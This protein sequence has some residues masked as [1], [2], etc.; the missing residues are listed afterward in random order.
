MSEVNDGMNRRHFLRNSVIGIGA[1]GTGLLTPMAN[2]AEKQGETLKIKEYRTL[3]RTGFKVSDISTGFVKDPAVL[4]Q[5]LDAGVN[6][7][8]TAE[9]YGNQPA[10]GKVMK[11]RDRK[12]VFITSKMEI[13]KDN[14][15]KEGFI[16]RARKCLEELQTDYIDCMMIHG[17]EKASTLKNEGFH[18]AMKQLKSEGRIRFVGVSHHGSNWYKDS[19]ESME[20]VLTAAANDGRFDVMLLAYNFVQQDNGAK[21]LEICKEKNIGASLMKVNPIGNISVLKER[22]EGLKKEG[23]E[24]PQRY[25][26]M[27]AKLEAK[28]KRAK[29]FIDKYKLG[30]VKRMRDAAIRFVLSNPNVHTVC[31]AFRNFDSLDAF[32]PLSGTRLE[33]MDK[34]KLAA[35]KEGCGVFYCRHACG[36]CEPSCPHHV[37]VNAIMRYNHYFEAQGKEKF[38]MKNYARLNGPKADLCA[39]CQ[40]HCETACPYG[41][42]VHA[43]LNLAHHTLTLV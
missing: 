2:A 28:A 36:L 30:D 17:P 5:L 31:C 22:M 6:Y 43:L 32:L 29:H 33:D 23:K 39:N 19:E 3:G 7:I 20:K 21:I 41:V 12:S 25:P 15:D 13:K 4:E 26:E 16:K 35:Y 40:G 14:L 38:A 27:I 24:I 18:Q 10:I 34:K 37:P 11:T 42:P 1:V 8:D 9:S